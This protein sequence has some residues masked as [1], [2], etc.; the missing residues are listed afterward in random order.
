MHAAPPPAYEA[1]F[2]RFLRFLE[3]EDVSNV[4]LERLLQ[5]TPSDVC[6][7]MNQK[8]YGR[9]HPT[10]EDLPTSARSNTLKAIKKKLSKFMPRQNQP[11]D[12]VQGRGNPTRSIAVQDLIKKVMKAEVRHQGKKSQA[13]RPVTLD[14][15]YCMLRICK[16]R[17]LYRL[18]SVLTLQWHVIG[19]VD[20]MMKLRLNE[21]SSNIEHKFAL[22]IQMRWSKNITEERESPRQILL[23][24]ITAPTA[25]LAVNY[26]GSCSSS[27]W[28]HGGKPS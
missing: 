8:A 19:R 2:Q 5:I 14:E 7:Y 4:T 20:D 27:M 9:Q 12:D 23:A 28:R 21:L 6:R 11:W 16:M 22:T 17:G 13:R 18:S 25:P 26:Y 1:E 24:R 10:I 3:V 15:F